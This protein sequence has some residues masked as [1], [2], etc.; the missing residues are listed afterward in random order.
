ME[1]NINFNVTFYLI[2][3]FWTERTCLRLFFTPNNKYLISGSADNT[4]KIFEIFIQNISQN[5]SNK[6]Q[7]QPI[8]NEIYHI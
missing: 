5:N 3:F 7:Q 8:L 4:F 1:I 2:F 6:Q